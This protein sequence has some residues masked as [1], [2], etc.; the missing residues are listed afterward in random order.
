MHVCEEHGVL[1]LAQGLCMDGGVHRAGLKLIKVFAQQPQPLICWI[2]PI[3]PEPGI[4]GVVVPAMK[5]LCTRQAL[6]SIHRC[7]AAHESFVS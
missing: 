2:I 6:S 7:T 5:V 1:Y 3:E 4:A